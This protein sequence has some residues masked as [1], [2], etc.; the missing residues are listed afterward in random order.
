MPCHQQANL[1][2]VGWH[3]VLFKNVERL[4]EAMVTL[5]V[6]HYCCFST[7]FLPL[8]KTVTSFAYY[9]LV[10]HRYKCFENIIIIKND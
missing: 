1:W 10:R 4:V 2:Q 6:R 8:L 5:Q 3:R 9:P 7:T